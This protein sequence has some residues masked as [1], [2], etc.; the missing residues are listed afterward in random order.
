MNE[1]QQTTQSTQSTNEDL[2]FMELVKR[3][4]H[5]GQVIKNNKHLCQLLNESE[6]KG[7]GYIY[8]QNNRKR[9]F[10]W[11]KQGQKFIITV[12][13]DIPLPKESIK[14]NNNIYNMYIEKLVLD[15]LVSQYQ[16][17]DPFNKRLY[18]TRDNM[19]LALNMVNI[20]YHYIKYNVIES[21]NYIKVDKDNL[22]E[23]YYINNRNLNDAVE[24]T[25]KRLE[26]KF[27]INWQLVQTI[28][29]SKN[30]VNEYNQGNTTKEIHR[31]ATKLEREYIT[32][33]ESKVS[34]LMGYKTKQEVFLS[35]KYLKFIKKV[36]EELKDIG[37]NILY[38]YKSYDIV[39]HKKVINELE[40]INQFLL[41]Y[42]TKNNVRITLNGIVSN[43]INKNTEKRH[44]KAKEELPPILGKR[45]V[46]ERDYKQ[47]ELIRRSQDTYLT[48]I[49][50]ITDT[51]I[52][53]ESKNIID[54]INQYNLEQKRKLDEQ[55]NEL[56]Y[57][58]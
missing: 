54:S 53:H 8:Q 13:H 1:L 4:L 51:I 16:S 20:N 3:T 33:Y 39:F 32:L 41:D 7:K 42:E 14:G 35:G 26:N 28:A 31:D 15:L 50:K 9:F 18:L 58:D 30:N 29:E 24:R 48:D 52:N 43:Q 2:L 27:L 6:K 40:N 46:N 49:N 23:F 57:G 55:I 47:L 25:L 45:R 10:D 56:L 11:I 44:N 36:C 38:Y 34:E 22:K 5:I 19:L 21:A 12:I 37:F 17:N